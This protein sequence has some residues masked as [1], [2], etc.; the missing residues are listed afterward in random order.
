MGQFLKHS[1]ATMD[2]VVISKKRLP[3]FRQPL[4]TVGIL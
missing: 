4:F 3:E 1:M 2:S